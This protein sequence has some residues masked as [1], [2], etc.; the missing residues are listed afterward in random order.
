[1]R[2]LRTRGRPSR[3]K[4]QETTS[5]LFK[6]LVATIELLEKDAPAKRRGRPSKNN[7]GTMMHFDTPRI[8]RPIIMESSFPIPVCI[9]VVTHN[10]QV[11]T[12]FI[13]SATTNTEGQETRIMAALPQAPRFFASTSAHGV[14]T[15]CAKKPIPKLPPSAVPP[16][17][18][19]WQ[20]SET[21]R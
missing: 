10:L 21:K 1:M 3:S 5:D 16:P 12:S 13:M 15:W 9:G 11:P 17:R 6:E 19:P 20:P 8:D 2:R 7:I 18:A 14:S 4:K